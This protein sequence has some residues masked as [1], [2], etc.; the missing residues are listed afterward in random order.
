MPARIAVSDLLI[1][2]MMWRLPGCICGANQSPI[3][4]PPFMTVSASALERSRNAATVSVPLESDSVS[5]SSA[6]KSAMAGS[7]SLDEASM[8]ALGTSS[9]TFRND[10]RVNGAVRQLARATALRRK[11]YASSNFVRLVTSCPSWVVRM[12][13]TIHDRRRQFS[14]S[15]DLSGGGAQLRRN[16]RDRLQRRH[17]KRRVREIRER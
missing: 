9:P 8:R 15:I 12:A 11:P 6:L 3:N 7:A 4:L 1:E 5:P 14:A 16:C 10:Q 13:R 2:K 17:G